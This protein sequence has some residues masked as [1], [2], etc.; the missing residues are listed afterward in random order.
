MKYI[1]FTEGIM[2]KVAISGYYGFKNFGD[3]AI[4]SVLTSHLKTIANTDITV[5]SSDCEFTEK[6]YGV[7]AVKRFDLKAVINTIM[8][9]DILISG[10]GSLLQDVTSLKSLIYY[11]FIIALGLLFNKKV[12]I[13]AQ[14]IGPLNS[15]TAKIVVKNLLKY[16]TYVT[17]RDENSQ[18]LLKDLGVKSEL[19]CD[20]VYSLNIK[21]E[22]SGD[23]VGIQLRE[24]KTM[25]QELLQKLALLVITK[26]S[27][28]KIE[29]FSLQK[30]QDYELSK[31]FEGL[32]KSFNPEIKTEIVE[33][34]IINRLSS[35]E[36]LIGM[37]F[38]AVLVALKCG[39][40][41]TAI[42][43]DV[44][45]EKIAKD[46]GIP[47][48][49]MDAH[50]NMEEIYQKMQN[51]NREDLLRFANSKLFDWKKFDELFII[52]K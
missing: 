30:T 19:V 29:I 37:R 15:N 8:S 45:V 21:P 7:K 38:H 10:G 49:S 39:I 6:T 2:V 5:F 36:Y 26:F 11:S 4:L 40:K 25:N 47:I 14:G 48:I 33:E 18:K 17:V 46:A 34:D 35:L 50:E 27:N 1:Q 43:Y 24:F 23:V 9:C 31:R 44:K 22:Q 41:T 42:N 13:F 32:V 51:L 16:C 12:I 28:K 3:E 20:P 52:S